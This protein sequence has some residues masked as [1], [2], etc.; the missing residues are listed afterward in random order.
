MDA[1]AVLKKRRDNRL[2]IVFVGD[3]S[4]KPALVQRA[5]DDELTNCEF[6]DPMPKRELVD[7]L[8]TADAGLMILDNIPAF[9]RGTSPNKFFDYIAAGLPI[10]N[11]YP[12]WL[13]ELIE[14]H[15]CGTAV[16]PADADVFADGLVS[17]SESP[18]RLAEQGKNARKLAESEFNRSELADQFAAVLEAYAG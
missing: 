2:R 8:K 14:K 4:E 13:A 6:V 16:A 7:F 5:T 10:L 3:G 15:D 9:Y 1:A 12:G 18:E 11:N 17:M